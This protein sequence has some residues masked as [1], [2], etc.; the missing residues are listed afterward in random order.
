[1]LLLVIIAFGAFYVGKNM[2]NTPSNQVSGIVSNTTNTNT[3]VDGLVVKVL[4]DARCI[5]C[6]TDK[7]ITSL[8]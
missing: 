6:N 7:L 5:D 4:D 2:N 3:T 1:V 8:Q